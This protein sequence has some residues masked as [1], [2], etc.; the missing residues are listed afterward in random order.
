M[1]DYTAIAKRK[2]KHA[3]GID[4]LLNGR[5]ATISKCNDSMSIILHSTLKEA[6]ESKD[7]MDK[8]CC[9]GNCSKAHEIVDLD[10][11]K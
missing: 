1:K 4:T 7:A 5:Y 9:G 10:K 6:I 11:Y 3:W 2:Y 8:F